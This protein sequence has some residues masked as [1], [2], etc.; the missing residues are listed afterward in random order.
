MRRVRA[1]RKGAMHAVRRLRRPHPA[2]R[3]LE[4]L[5]R[6]LDKTVAQAKSGDKDLN[7]LLEA[8]LAPDMYA[9]PRQIQIASDIARMGAAK[10]AG[11]DPPSFPDEEK[12]FPELQQRIA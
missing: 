4:N 12:T 5:S 9:F 7:I 1:K 11:E 3:G 8:R 6:I 10:L 2:V